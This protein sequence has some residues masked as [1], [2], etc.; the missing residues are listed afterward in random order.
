[1]KWV[2]GLFFVF[3]KGA[4][5]CSKFEILQRNLV[6]CGG[7]IFIDSAQHAGIRSKLVLD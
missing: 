4:L 3:H 2:E 1:M 5:L 7:R 6:F